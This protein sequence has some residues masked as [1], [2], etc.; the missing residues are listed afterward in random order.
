MERV[1]RKYDRKNASCCG[2]PLMF[3]DM[4]RGQEIQARNLDDA[5]DAGAA[6]MTFLCP[7]C[8][9]GLGVGTMERGMDV[10]MISDL[11]R[12]ALGE[13]IPAYSG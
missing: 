10:Y 6:A 1:A 9:R 13:E 3:R 11:C 8:I 7:V 4:S 12:L 2:L 5:K